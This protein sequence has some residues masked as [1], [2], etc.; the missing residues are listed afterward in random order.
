MWMSESAANLA[1]DTVLDAVTHMSVHSAI[2]NDSGTNEISGGSPAYARKAVDW[3]AAASR[4]KSK[5]ATDPVFDIPNGVT[6]MFYGLWTASTAGSFRGFAPI[7]GG[8]IKGVGSASNSGD[9]IGSKAH[10]LA[11]GERVFLRTV[12]GES[13]PGGLDVTVVY[14]VVG[15]TTDTFQ[16][17]LTSG[18]SAVAITSDGELF[19]QR[20]IPETYGSQGTL[21]CDD[22]DFDLAG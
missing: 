21:T 11:N 22:A 2:P 3:G 4:S 20:V 1:L 7:A 17:S 15:V 18:G 9:V 12:A 6:A 14:F 8:N 5:D 16:V 10:G 13:I 19:F